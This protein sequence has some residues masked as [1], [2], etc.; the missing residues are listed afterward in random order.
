MFISMEK[1]EST[2]SLVHAHIYIHR[3]KKRER[4]IEKEKKGSRVSP[5]THL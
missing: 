3:E 4:Y 5:L 2:Y 1:D